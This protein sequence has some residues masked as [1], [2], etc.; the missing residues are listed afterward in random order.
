M[1]IASIAL[2]AS[3]IEK[4]FTLSRSEGGVDAAFS[5]EPHEMRN[6]VD[7]SIRAWQALGE[8][9]YGPTNE[10]RASLKYHRSVFVVQDMKK[11]DIFTKKNIRIIRPGFGLEPKYYDVF[12]GKRV[13]QDIQRGTPLSWGLLE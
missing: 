10:E 9:N 6:L 7:E 5:L 12:L 8:I 1:A 11:G 4:H 2:G 13:K 3:V